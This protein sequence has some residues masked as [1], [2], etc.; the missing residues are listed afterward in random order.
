MFLKILYIIVL[1][2]F[3]VSFIFNFIMS[4]IKDIKAKKAIKTNPVHQKGIIRNIEKFK[5]RV[6]LSVEF[7]SNHNR[8]LLSETFELFESDIKGKEYYV[9]QE[10]DMIYKDVTNEKRVRIFP[11]LL[12][13]LKIKL[14][15]G[16]LFL[17]IALI[18]MGAF[19]LG[20]TLNLYA[21]KQAWTT[22][23]QLIGESG[24]YENSFYMLLMFVVY[25]LISNYMVQSLIDTPRKDIQNYLKFYGN[26]TKA[27]VVTYKFGK[28]KNSK[29]NKESIIDLE[30]STSDGTQVHTKLTSFLYTESQE[31][32]IDIL[33]DPKHPKTVVYLKQ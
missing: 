21:Q 7:S 18:V 5:G 14:D 28:A 31:E 8:L 20:N 29:G 10:V 22:D 17:N 32:Y 11:L 3:L 25:F 1:S 26:V 16:P 24:I 6:Y 15:K 13:D 19:I 30:F 23:I 12:S 9:G 27:R 4:L 2:M 33:Y